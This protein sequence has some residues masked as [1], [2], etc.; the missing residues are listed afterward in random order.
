MLGGRTA[1]ATSRWSVNLPPE[2]PWWCNRAQG[3]LPATTEASAWRVLMQRKV[4]YVQVPA[5]WKMGGSL[6]KPV[7]TCQGSERLL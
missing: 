6:S 4:V 1:R 5:T 2:R 7:S 3:R